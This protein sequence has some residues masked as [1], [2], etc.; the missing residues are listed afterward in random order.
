MRRRERIPL[1]EGEVRAFELRAHASTLIAP[2]FLLVLTSGVAAFLA[3][4][5]PDTGAQTTLR[6]ILAATAGAIVLRWSIWPFLAWYGTS[7]VLTNRRLILREGVL[8]RRG[9]DVPLARVIGSDFTRTLLQRMFGAGR[10]VVSTA[11]QHGELVL[12]NAPMV[13]D[14][15]RVIASAVAASAQ[16]RQ[17]AVSTPPHQ[18][19]P[20][21][22]F[23]PGS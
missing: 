7:W 18:Q 6:S 15:Q 5:V 23:R 13:V 12:E 20:P 22:Q 16:P 17:V 21:Q 9:I 11:G 14:V 4:T 3:G 8:S 1:L 19:F 2:A 10:L